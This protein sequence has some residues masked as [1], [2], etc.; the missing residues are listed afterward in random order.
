MKLNVQ[1]FR[2]AP[3]DKLTSPITAQGKSAPKAKRPSLDI[4]PYSSGVEHYEGPRCSLPVTKAWVVASHRL[5][6]YRLERS[7]GNS[8][9]SV[10]PANDFLLHRG[11]NAH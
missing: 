6:A 2:S 7:S 1:R 4:E 9:G 8:V 5:E 3:A 10:G 11:M